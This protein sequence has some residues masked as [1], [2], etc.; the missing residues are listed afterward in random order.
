MKR[1]A[2][3]T[4]V[5]CALALAGASACAGE[6]QQE[7]A[8]R[9]PASSP[10]SQP[11]VSTLPSSVPSFDDA[12]RQA[13]LAALRLV[14]GGLAADEDKSVEQARTACEDLA[15]GEDEGTVR[16]GTAEALGT[17]RDKASAFVTAARTTLCPQE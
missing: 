13:F 15:R 10:A 5:V 16:D 6:S 11:P 9:P 14:D 12:R 17:S 7:P 1:T 2:A 4:V 8:P 3:T